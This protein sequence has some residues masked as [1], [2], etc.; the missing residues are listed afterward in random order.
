MFRKPTFW[1]VLVL[2]AAASAW[3][4]IANFSRAFPIVSLDITMDRAS[5]LASARALEAKH[6]F[7]PSGYEQAASFRGD[8]EVQS[9]VELEAGGTAAFREMFASGRYQPFQWYVR[10]YREGEAREAK[11]YFTPQ[12]EPY[13]FVVKLPEKEAGPAL[14]AEQAQAIAERGAAEWK[15]DLAT[16]ALVEKSRDVR[17]AGRVDH[18]FVYER[19]DVKIGDGRYRLRLVVG[20]DRLT[21]LQHFVK[22]P[23]AFGRR[24]EEMRSANSGISII[25][26]VGL[27]LVYLIGGCGVG[28]FVLGRQRWIIWRTP[29]MW[30]VF[31]AF[32]QLLEG[33]NQWPLT[34]LDYDTAV[35]SGGFVAQ[36]IGM[37]V[38][39]FGGYAVV[40][41]VSFMAAESLTRRAFP[42]HLQLWRIWSPT[43]AP[44][45][46]MLGQTVA[47]YLL[48]ALFFGYEV[49]FYY[50]ASHGLGWWMPSDT[51]VQPDVLA[52]HQPWLSAIAVSTQAGF[53]EEALFRAVPLACAALLGQRYGRRAWWIA[54]A[55]ILQAIIFGSGHAG[56]ANQPAYARVVELIV[57]SLMFGGLYLV[58]GLWPAIVLHF[59]YDVVMFAIPVFVTSA[60][61]AWADRMMVILLALVPLWIVI[62]GRRRAGAWTEAGAADRNGAWQPPPKQT[63]VQEVT[64]RAAAVSPFVVRALPV[65]GVAGLAL[66]AFFA[67]FTYDAPP[68]DV[69]RVQAEQRARQALAERGVTLDSNWKALPQLDGSPGEPHD[70][71]WRTAGR[72]AYNRLLGQF[73]VPP[74][75]TVRFARFTG[76]VAE[77][78]EEYQVMVGAR[79][80]V[81]GV[82][83]LLPED[84][85]A[86]SLA[87]ADARAL[88]HRTLR[89]RFNF[90]AASLKEV[91]AKPSQQKNRTDWLF[92]FAVATTPPLAQGET[93]ATVS[94]AGSEVNASGRFVFVPEEWTRAERDRQ[95]LPNMINIACVALTALAAI[96]GIIFGIVSWVRR[97][98]SLRTFIVLAPLLLAVN[99]AAQFNQWTQVTAAFSTAQPYELQVTVLVVTLLI[100]LTALALGVAVLGGYVTRS[101]R[102]PQ[103]GTAGRWTAGAS[104]AFAAAGIGAVMSRLAPS[105]QPAWAS[106]DPLAAYVPWL[107]PPLDAV[108]QVIITTVIGWFLLGLVDR[109]TAGWSRRKALGAAF[110][111]A[112]GF[113]VAGSGGIDSIGW[114]AAS[115]AVAG[116]LGLAAYV[117]V[118]RA[119]PEA[120]PV[121]VAG[122]HA[123]GAIKAAWSG[124]YPGVA[125]SQGLRV[126]TLLATAW[127]LMY[128]W[129]ARGW[130]QASAP[131][132]PA[133][134]S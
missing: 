134:Q 52:S 4:G 19:P 48:V 131:A 44:S 39:M 95:T 106:Y 42:N 6:R 67:N 33:I 5:A 34:W 32:L 120:L 28:L 99:L 18:T 7:G 3:L 59:G 26:V 51:L 78:A 100:G 128:L 96:G 25:S 41:S 104:V 129:R 43:V 82:R 30:G 126:V 29:V 21:A 49:L 121:A 97:G 132:T 75:W 130:R 46:T 2:V 57:P 127:L 38:L 122:T 79:G 109:L 76:D 40:L 115:G 119:A 105:L 112:L 91:E 124:A 72:D 123:L 74:R 14:D 90:D 65:A 89:D 111:V 84:K 116:V 101:P 88:A 107:V 47:G 86:P 103:L 93:R 15:I 22:V 31:V 1:V 81:T 24:F 61:G 108:S 77:R 117:V 80:T 54:G 11:L 110:F 55:M 53:W 69:G 98:F 13:G 12:G 20:G 9:F 36:Q 45:K 71:V 102:G 73:L 114:W 125:L 56:Y 58:F 62:G 60:P 66:W 87:E 70:F 8:Q 133:A 16:F 37:Q 23:E 94:I 64:A 113:V 17:P 118:L 35:S 92:T 10:H 27:V 83:H 85:A 68:L 50:L 63:A